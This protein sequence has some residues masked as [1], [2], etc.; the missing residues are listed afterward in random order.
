M[1]PQHPAHIVAPRDASCHLPAAFVAP[2]G[3]ASL[4]V[5]RL[6]GRSRR[7]AQRE[8]WGRQ[9]GRE[10]VTSGGL[11]PAPPC[12][13][14]CD[15]TRGERWGHQGACGWRSSRNGDGDRKPRARLGLMVCVRGYALAMSPWEA[16]GWDLS[17]QL[18]WQATPN[19]RA[20]GLR[21]RRAEAWSSCCQRDWQIRD[22][23]AD[24]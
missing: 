23:L 1:A 4:E 21:Q 7:R 11:V 6:P 19:R 2:E 16:A 12:G 9:R 24:S 20:G 22:M 3:A 10:R 15:H 8:P 13:P 14:A 18:S 17:T 5:R